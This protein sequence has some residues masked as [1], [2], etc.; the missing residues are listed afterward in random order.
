[1]IRLSTPRLELFPLKENQIRPY[2]QHP[3]ALEIELGFPISRKIL[4]TNVHRALRI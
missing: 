4:D 1:M 2:L 3:A